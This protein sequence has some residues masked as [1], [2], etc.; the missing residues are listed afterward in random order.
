MGKV[1]VTPLTTVDSS[2]QPM[3]WTNWGRKGGISFPSSNNQMIA[4]SKFGFNESI[5]NQWQQ[6]DR[7]VYILDGN[8]IAKSSQA[9]SIK[10]LNIPLSSKM[11]ADVSFSLD[12]FTIE[13]VTYIYDGA[14]KYRYYYPISSNGT[15]NMTLPQITFDYLQGVSVYLTV[16][17]GKYKQIN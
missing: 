1:M 9:G 15:E 5:T 3:E 4:P 10:F 17:T 12:N 2:F 6:C 14:V 16:Y 7:L 13:F 11:G 8:L